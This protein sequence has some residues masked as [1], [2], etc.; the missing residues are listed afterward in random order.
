MSAAAGRSGRSWR[1]AALPPHMAELDEDAALAAALQQSAAEAAAAAAE[2]A[3]DPDLAAALRLSV[4]AA[5]APP[6]PAACAAAGGVRQANARITAA[7]AMELLRAVHASEDLVFED[8]SVVPA[9][10]WAAAAGAT[11]GAA[12]AGAAVTLLLPSADAAA[13]GGQG[14]RGLPAADAAVKWCS[15]CDARLDSRWS[16]NAWVFRCA[17]CAVDL[18]GACYGVEAE[19]P[20]A[21]EY[22]ALP[23]AGAPGGM[24]R[25]PAPKGPPG[26]RPGRW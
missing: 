10:A 5:P 20:C 7:G 17:D 6:A 11:G 3:A 26:T 8:L 13:G 9:G 4:R 22:E 2:A 12:G 18:C 14:A 15:L 19:R 21:H 24:P 16:R 23:P 1:R 25:A